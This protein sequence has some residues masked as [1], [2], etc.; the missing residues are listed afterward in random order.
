MSAFI[1]Q[2]LL[3]TVTG[4][5]ESFFGTLK[6]ESLH[7]KVFAIKDDARQENF[8]YIEVFYN[9]QRIHSALDFVSP[10]EFEM[11]NAA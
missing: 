9:R 6:I 5:E 1:Y 10:A 8:K 2:A 3:L 7:R 4:R 11:A